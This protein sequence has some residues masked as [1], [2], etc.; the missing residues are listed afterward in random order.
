M[1]QRLVGGG[2][3]SAPGVGRRVLSSLF[4]FDVVGV[5]QRLGL[6]PLPPDLQVPVRHLCSSEEGTHFTGSPAMSELNAR[7]RVVGS[8]L[9]CFPLLWSRVSSPPAGS[10]DLAFQATSRCRDRIFSSSLLTSNPLGLQIR[11]RCPIVQFSPCS[12]L[13]THFPPQSCRV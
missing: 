9:P 2:R 6:L 3:G 7:A 4:Y 1:T 13:L 11:E 10:P 8:S 5:E 12:P